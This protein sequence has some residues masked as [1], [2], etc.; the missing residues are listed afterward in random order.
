ML[1]QSQHT[2]HSAAVAAWHNLTA[3]HAAQRRRQLKNF[4]MRDMAA[5][6][7]G[8]HAC[9][10]AQYGLQALQEDAEHEDRLPPHDLLP[11]VD[12][13]LLIK[14][15]GLPAGKAAF[16]ALKGK[17]DSLHLE[18]QHGRRLR[19]SSGAAKPACTQE[20][21][22]DLRAAGPAGG[23]TDIPLTMALQSVESASRTDAS[24][25]A[26]QVEQL[27]MLSERPMCPFQCSMLSREAAGR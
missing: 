27:L 9:C 3:T 6:L 22:L 5:H 13:V 4:G 18:G 14:V 16:E 19:F 21:L 25:K 2:C 11:K 23:L 15:A 10:L 24:G 7:P 12:D 20:R 17:G 1:P 26:A 8:R